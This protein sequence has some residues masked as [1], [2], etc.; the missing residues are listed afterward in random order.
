MR[1]RTIN[2]QPTA[3]NGSFIAGMAASD[4]I[5]ETLTY[6]IVSG[7]TSNSFAIDPA[8]GIVTI[9]DNSLISTRLTPLF[10][11][12]IEVQD[13]GY[14][15]LFPLKTTQAVLRVQLD[16]AVISW[17]GLASDANWS[18]GAN[19]LAGTAPPENST[20]NFSGSNQRTNRNDV[21]TQAGQI[22]FNTDGFYVIGNPLTLNGGIA[23]RGT[24]VWA[25]DSTLNDLQNFNVSLGN[26]VIS[27]TLTGFGGINKMG[28]ANLVLLA[29]N[30]FTGP[31]IINS[32]SVVITNSAVISP[33]NELDVHTAGTLDVRGMQDAFMIPATQTLKGNGT[34][35]WAMCGWTG[36][37]L[38]PKADAKSS[39]GYSFD[40]FFHVQKRSGAKG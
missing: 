10:N 36:S 12:L 6:R 14:G 17:S 4:S 38:R 2:L 1:S 40:K 16:S 23:N 33:A 34:W 9:A 18:S 25:I 39:S 31:I 28:S 37:L 11:L 27:K 13:S 20:L 22:L 15:D 26:L 3:T 30:R 8:S 7:N 35:T 21:L 19:W 29:T 24:N 32:G 5:L